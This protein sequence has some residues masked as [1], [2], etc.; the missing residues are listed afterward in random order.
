MDFRMNKIDLRQINTNFF[1]IKRISHSP[2][3]R[4]RKQNSSI[5]TIIV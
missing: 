4:K 5:F 3:E 2:D 1:V